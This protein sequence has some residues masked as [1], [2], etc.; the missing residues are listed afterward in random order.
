M[1]PVCGHAESHGNRK[2]VNRMG[3]LK[4]DGGMMTVEAA[5]IVPVISLV[6]AG[7]T[8][9]FLFLLDISAAK[10]E[11]IRMA[12]ETASAWK[13]G[14]ELTTGDYQIEDR[15]GEN[16]FFLTG[17]HEKELEQKAK[18]RLI[19]RINE[20][21][22]IARLHQGNVWFSMG[23]VKAEAELILCWPLTVMEE[24]FGKSFSFC[25]SAAS[26]VDNWQEILRMGESLVWK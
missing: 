20:R 13:T 24:Y 5:A 22:V 17:S 3:R 21:L 12:G 23:R 10:S 11:V 16:S 15:L 1:Q 19:R 18:E 6:L 2:E 26:P 25:C 9:L 4:K 8:L 14:G 7:V